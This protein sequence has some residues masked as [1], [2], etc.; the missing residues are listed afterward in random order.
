[1]GRNREDA[2]STIRFSCGYATTEPEIKRAADATVR[3]V[4]EVKSAMEATAER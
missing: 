4:K 3:A 2:D 1:M